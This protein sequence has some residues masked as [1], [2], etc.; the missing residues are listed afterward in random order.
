MSFTLSENEI[1][2]LRERLNCLKFMLFVEDSYYHNYSLEI[3]KRYFPHLK[4][5]KYFTGY[6]T[7]GV[8]RASFIKLKKM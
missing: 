3:K 5:R 2:L 4:G 7:G 6:S 1:N 8:R